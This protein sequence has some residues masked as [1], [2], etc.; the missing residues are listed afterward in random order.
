VPTTTG[1]VPANPKSATTTTETKK[2]VDVEKQKADEAKK[3]ADEAKR[4]EFLEKQ[5]L[6]EAKDLKDKKD[7]KDAE[8]ERL[9][10]IANR[11][12][13]LEK[14]RISKELE[15]LKAHNETTSA[16]TDESKQ[17]LN[18]P[19]TDRQLKAKE[20]LELVEQSNKVLNEDSAATQLQ[21]EVMLSRIERTKQFLNARG[22]Q[23][24]PTTDGG[25][26]DTKAKK[27]SSVKKA[28][29]AKKTKSAKKVASSKTAKSDNDDSGGDSDGSTETRVTTEDLQGLNILTRIATDKSGTMLKDK[30]GNIIWDKYLTSNSPNRTYIIQTKIKNKWELVPARGVSIPFHS[31][32]DVSKITKYVDNTIFNKVGDSVIH[33]NFRV[34]LWTK[35]LRFND[36]HY[37]AA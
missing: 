29:P 18:A 36:K 3:K 5:N 28:S 2:K 25:D 14:V 35:E 34:T 19:L 7:L 12:K 24:S 27:S 4:K 20:M 15:D 37:Y 13:Y 23:V 32:I 21:N 30:R 8:D 31:F 16:E 22:K 9:A 11:N 33:G 10:T 6:A 1:T 17:V 26:D